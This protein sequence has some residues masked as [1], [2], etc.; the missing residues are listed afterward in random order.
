MH[1]AFINTNIV[2]NTI[3]IRLCIANIRQRII[4]RKNEVKIRCYGRVSYGLVA[5]R[6]STFPRK[7]LLT[8]ESYPHVLHAAYLFACSQI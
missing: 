8:K 6:G 3:K 4:C 5:R 1:Q 2:L 7:I